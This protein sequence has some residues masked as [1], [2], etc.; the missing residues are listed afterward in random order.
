MKSTDITMQPEIN[1]ARAKLRDVLAKYGTHWEMRPMT[2]DLT[3]STRQPA[4]FL[5]KSMGGGSYRPITQEIL[6]C[7][8]LSQVNGLKVRTVAYSAEAACD[9]RVAIE[10]LVEAFDKVTIWVDGENGRSDSLMIVESEIHPQGARYSDS[11]SCTTTH[12]SQINKF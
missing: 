5:L 6:A 4:R 2:L 3:D 8:I 1:A 11:I 10:G 9:L 7:E 12:S